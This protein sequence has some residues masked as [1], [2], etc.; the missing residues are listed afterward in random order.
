MKKKFAPHIEYA[1]YEIVYHGDAGD[2]TF[3]YE[4]HWLTWEITD[5]T[6][7]YIKGSLRNISPVPVWGCKGYRDA[8]VT[9]WSQIKQLSGI[10]IGFKKRLK[11]FKDI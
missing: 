9:S 8:W 1:P 2:S 7:D 3:E 5:S 10:E 4:K 6:P 11:L